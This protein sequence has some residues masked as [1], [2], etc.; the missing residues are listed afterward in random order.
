MFLKI[1]WGITLA[2]ACIASLDLFHVMADGTSA[3]Q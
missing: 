1:C 3:P 2:V